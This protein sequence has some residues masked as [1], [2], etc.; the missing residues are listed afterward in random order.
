MRTATTR[1]R[2]IGRCVGWV[3]ATVISLQADRTRCMVRHEAGARAALAEAVASINR[4]V[5]V[6]GSSLRSG[7]SSGLQLPADGGDDL[8]AV[9]PTTTWSPVHDGVTD[10][11]RVQ[12]PRRGSDRPGTSAFLRWWRNQPR[13]RGVVMGDA[14]EG[15]AFIL[16]EFDEAIV[17]Q[18]AIV[19]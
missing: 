18:Q 11:R 16:H 9:E 7:G 19:E 2:R 8:P 14:K 12:R 1:R 17:V 6:G 13:S 5:K 10:A 3:W 4:R 15:Q